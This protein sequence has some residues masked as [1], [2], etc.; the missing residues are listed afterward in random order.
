MEQFVIAEISKSIK[1]RKLLPRD[2]V[3]EDLK[4]RLITTLING[5]D[6]M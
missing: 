5:A 4:L 3:D 1:Q 6:G 2:E